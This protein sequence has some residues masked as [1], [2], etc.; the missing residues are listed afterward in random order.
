MAK[1]RN[2]ETLPFFSSVKYLRFLE[3]YSFPHARNEAVQILQAISLWCLSW[4]SDTQRHKKAGKVS[5]TELAE[6]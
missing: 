3:S 4:R 5:D 6:V 1:L 2:R